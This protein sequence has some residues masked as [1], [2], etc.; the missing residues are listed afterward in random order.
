MTKIA[1]LQ[2]SEVSL[3]PK[4]KIWGVKNIARICHYFIPYS[5]PRTFLG[6]GWNGMEIKKQKKKILIK[7]T[8]FI[9]TKV[10][11]YRKCPFFV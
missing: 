10:N 2:C 5:I 3:L 9:F 8:K 6:M 7:R 4:L 11:I 1:L